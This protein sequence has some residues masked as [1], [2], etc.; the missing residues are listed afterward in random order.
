LAEQFIVDGPES[1]L[2]FDDSV[3]DKRYSR[4]I[5]LVEP[6]VQRCGAGIGAG[7]LRRKPLSQ[8]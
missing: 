6:S 7:H 8:Q 5:E 2:V 4:F 1:R 3:Q